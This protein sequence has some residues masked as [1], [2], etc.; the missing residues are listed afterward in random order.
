MTEKFEHKK[1]LG[2]HFLNSDYV[3]KKMCDASALQ[4]G[5]TVLEIGPGTG[6]L[7]KEIIARGAKVIA[8]EADR[9][10]ISALEA[11]FQTEIA[12]GQLTIHHHDARSLDPAQFNLEK[13]GYKVIS[14]IPYYLSGHLFRAL[15]DTD[16]QP[17][18]LVFLVQKEVAQRIA[19]DRK[20]SL[21]SLSIKVF[22]DPSYICTIKKSHFTPPPKID[23]AIVAVR[24][25][26]RGNF[27]NLPSDFFFK[28]LNLGFC[29]KRKQ[30]IGNLSAEFPRNILEKILTDLSLPL[31]TRA[32]DISVETW[33]E[34]CSKLYS[35]V[36][37]QT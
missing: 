3:P 28:L 20:E 34:L 23:S 22:G 6:I 7:T 11:S 13:Q 26:G 33:L 12:R 2:Q 21:L 9:R 32:E 16:C 10:A 5:E 4:T 14:N 30:L 19:R 36:K 25:I 1:S 37:T 35:T 29:Q 15:L 31:D 17:T 18:D 27:D 8:I 24:K